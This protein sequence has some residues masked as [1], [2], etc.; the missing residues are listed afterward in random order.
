[1]CLQRFLPLLG[2]GKDYKSPPSPPDQRKSTAVT[3]IVGVPAEIV[4]H[5]P[6]EVVG[7]PHDEEVCVEGEEVHVARM[8]EEE[9]EDRGGYFCSQPR[10]PRTRPPGCK[11]LDRGQKS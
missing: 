5:V 11:S 4:D 6:M 3:A 7:V 2:A 10:L 8:Q 1:M 9:A